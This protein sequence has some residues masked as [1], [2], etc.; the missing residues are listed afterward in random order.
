MTA[1]KAVTLNGLVEQ[2]TVGI[3]KVTSSNPATLLT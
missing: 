3:L 2:V 1:S